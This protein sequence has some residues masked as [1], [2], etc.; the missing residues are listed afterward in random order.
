MVNVLLTR[1]IQVSF[2]FTP[3]ADALNVRRVQRRFAQ[4][5]QVADPARQG[6]NHIIDGFAQLCAVE[7]TDCI[8]NRSHVYQGA[9][10]LHSV[11][12]SNRYT[13]GDE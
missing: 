2:C 9:Q 7:R 8:Y 10:L 12:R 1:R 3:D 5:P 4:S 11:R 6:S 13:S